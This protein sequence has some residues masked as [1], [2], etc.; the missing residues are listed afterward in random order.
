MPFH[1]LLNLTLACWLILPLSC[2]AQGE[3]SASYK[4]LEYK[5][6]DSLC[7]LCFKS[8]I[9]ADHTNSKTWAHKGIEIADS[10]QYLAGKFNC[11]YGLAISSEMQGSYYFAEEYAK[12]ALSIA[13]RF[14]DSLSMAKAQ[15]TIGIIYGAKADYFKSIDAFL[16][17]SQIAKALDIL[18]LQATSLT[19][20]AGTYNNIGYSNKDSTNYLSALGYLE[21][22][23]D[24]FIELKDSTSIAITLNSL[25]STLNSLNRLD[26]ALEVI[27][28]GISISQS[29]NCNHCLNKG[30]SFKGL[31]L[32]K[33]K[34]ETD[35][36]RFHK[37]SLRMSHELL[38]TSSVIVSLANVGKT[39][40]ELDSRD[41]CQYYLNQALNL[42]RKIDQKRVLQYLN[43]DLHNFY[44]QK[45]DYKQAYNYYKDYSELKDSLV[46]ERNIANIN[47]IVA[48]Y[49][50]LELK[51]VN[52]L[53]E[54]DNRI[55]NLS[56]KNTRFLNS[57]FVTSIFLLVSTI[58]LILLI[59]KGI[60]RNRSRVLKDKTEKYLE[61][62]EK[63]ALIISSINED[64]AEDAVKISS[65]SEGNLRYLQDRVTVLSLR[66]NEFGDWATAGKVRKASQ[67]K[68]KITQLI[69]EISTGLRDF[70][71][72]SKPQNS[73]NSSVKR[74]ID[75]QDEASYFFKG[76]KLA[77]SGK[78]KF[79]LKLIIAHS[80]IVLLIIILLYFVSWDKIEPVTYILN[81]VFLCAEL[82]IVLKFNQ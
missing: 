66:L 65:L 35:A 21:E 10:I 1:K 56:I 18:K 77:L 54:R 52:K 6:V 13:Q 17:V 34:R 22:A 2:F 70:K 27:N 9:R 71:T 20:I 12:E 81:S 72:D 67:S 28:R 82:A 51:N 47:E 4:P 58:V 53:L 15:N 25:S 23:L 46:G 61:Y 45:K 42:A 73:L 8:A 5:T 50:V 32:Q 19:N 78:Q 38:D 16:K 62:K 7:N 64:L 26:S 60:I 74:L 29:I 59:F 36:L 41:S 31:I 44:I 24:I 3:E 43:F 40:C 69:E 79:L 80:L 76:K 33:M 49:Q 55:K 11:L 37:R 14:N 68:A 39:L 30:Y 57:L 75:I 63:V 48:K